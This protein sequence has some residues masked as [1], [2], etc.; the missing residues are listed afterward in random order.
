MVCS[1]LLASKQTRS[2]GGGL[3]GFSYT[4]PGRLRLAEKNGQTM[5]FC[6]IF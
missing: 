1:Y 4:Q 2:P 3:E 5:K 6:F